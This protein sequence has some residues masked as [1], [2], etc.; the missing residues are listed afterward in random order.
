[1]LPLQANM[2]SA[3]AFLLIFYVVS[4]CVQKRRSKESQFTNDSK[5][6]NVTG[7]HKELE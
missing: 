7:L 3:F 6:I 2:T 5:Q 1:M 4:L